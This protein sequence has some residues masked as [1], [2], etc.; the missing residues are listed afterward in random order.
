MKGLNVKKKT[1]APLNGE[2]AIKRLAEIKQIIEGV[3]NRAMAGDIVTPTLQEMTQAEISR[4]YA[5]AG[6]RIRK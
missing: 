5:L 6:G 3:D 1:L 4:I 2:N